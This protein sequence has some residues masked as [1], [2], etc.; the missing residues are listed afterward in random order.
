MFERCGLRD[1]RTQDDV[2]SRHKKKFAVEWVKLIWCESLG[3]EDASAD[4]VKRA[5]VRN[6]GTVVGLCARASGQASTKV[7]DV[8]FHRAVIIN[9]FTARATILLGLPKRQWEVGNVLSR[10]TGPK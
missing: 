8:I 9:N 6:L 7:S 4:W 1:G 10:F 3:F 5:S 2:P